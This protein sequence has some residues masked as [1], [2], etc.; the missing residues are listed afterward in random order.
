MRKDPT[1]FRERFAKWKAGEKVY[2]NGLPKYGDG[3]TNVI[4][5]D[6]QGLSDPQFQPQI[7]AAKVQMTP[8]VVDDTAYRAQKYHPGTTREQVQELYNNT[9]YIGSYN[10]GMLARPSVGAYFSDRDDY[11]FVRIGQN[12]PYSVKQMIAHESGHVLDRKLFGGRTKEERDVVRAAYGNIPGMTDDEMFQFNREVRQAISEN[13][14]NAIKEKLDAVLKE[15]KGKDINWTIKNGKFG[16]ADE[17]Y[18]ANI[19]P[20]AVRKAL[21]E[22]AQNKYT[23]DKGNGIMLAKNGK[24]AGLPAYGGGKSTKKGS[25]YL[26]GEKIRRE[27]DVPYDNSSYDYRRANQLGYE[28]DE[29]GQMP[30]RDWI[31]GR[32]LKTPTHPTESLS[33]YTDLGLGYDV[34]DKY[35]NTY[36]Q[37]NW[38]S[39][40]QSRL[41]EYK[42]GKEQYDHT[43]NFLKQYEGFKDTTYLDGNGVPTIGYGFTDSS[44][45]KKGRMSK[46][47]ADRQLV[48][49]IEKREDRLSKLK[50]WNNLSEDSKTALRS[51]Y[52]N[53]PAGFGK[54]TKFI[55]YWNAGDY[56]RAINEVD[57]GMNDKNNPGL[58]KRRL[59]EQKMLRQDPFLKTPVRSQIGPVE[60][61]MD[62][63]PR[64][65]PQPIIVPATT[66]PDYSIQTMVEK[67]IPATL[68]SRNNGDSP[69]YG[70]NDYSFRMPSLKEYIERNVMRPQW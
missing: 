69:I 24:S 34:F 70:G 55:R 54:D 46:S 37:P 6:L 52:Y 61:M 4:P 13:N 48:R 28:P 30:S 63:S 31:T 57:A 8:F 14:R 10:K 40:W 60:Q 62:N 38:G 49:E 41:P 68:N 9:P 32:Y 23:F 51:Y 5:E 16:H 64:F 39:T 59:Q 66:Q 25:Y 26:P 56:E 18:K 7:D 42:R 43:V 29:T 67:S 1:E 11:P 19:D 47:E 3:T 44:L 27:I 65:I 58:R 17:A 20:E 15:I 35:G 53:Y 50:N 33:I 12:K 45:V 36:S 22:V 21:L 2:E